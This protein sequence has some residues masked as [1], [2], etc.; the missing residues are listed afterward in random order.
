MLDAVNNTKTEQAG[1]IDL[2]LAPG[3][4]NA[5][6]LGGL[7]ATSVQ[8]IETVGAVETYNETFDLVRPVHSWTQW[9]SEPIVRE[10][11]L[12]LF[13]LPRRSGSRLRVI[14]S[15]P[16][17][18]ARCGTLVTGMAREM[19]ETQWGAGFRVK[20]NSVYK[21]KG[22][23]IVELT[24]RP[25]ARRINATIFAPLAMFDEINRLMMEF[26]GSNLLWSFSGDYKTLNAFGF[27]EDF[28]NALP[29]AAG[30]FYN[31]QVLGLI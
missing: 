28:D 21:D 20:P 8:V 9:D 10:E 26:E 14:I 5:L 15:K 2:T 25:S 19:G 23:G 1:A 17:G 18:T 7:E 11:D 16:G 3:L 22:F 6:Y 29:T 30:S 12:T 13:E 4:H 27:Y 31:L 24:K